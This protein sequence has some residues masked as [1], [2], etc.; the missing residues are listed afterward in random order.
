MEQRRVEN[1]VTT[2]SEFT[3][4]VAELRADIVL[5]IMAEDAWDGPSVKPGDL[6]DDQIEWLASWMAGCGWKK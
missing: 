5:G 2:M 3:N 4:T 1:G 6:T